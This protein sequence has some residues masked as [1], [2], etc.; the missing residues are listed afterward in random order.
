[1]TDYC[2]GVRLAAESRGKAAVGSAAFL[3]RGSLSP[4]LGFWL[5]RRAGTAML[6]GAPSRPSGMLAPP[7][8][9]SSRAATP[10]GLH[11]TPRHTPR[12]TPRSPAEVAA[13]KARLME[14]ARENIRRGI[15]QDENS[16]PEHQIRLLT[17]LDLQDALL[18]YLRNKST[19]VEAAAAQISDSRD[20]KLQRERKE[21]A[22]RVVKLAVEKELPRAAD[23]LVQALR[24]ESGDAGRWYE[25]QYGRLQR[26]A[27]QSLELYREE[28]TAVLWPTFAHVFLGLMQRKLAERARD[29]FDEHR[30]EHEDT[31]G[32]PDSDIAALSAITAP[33]QLPKPWGE[34]RADVAGT[35]LQH[36]F[37]VTMSRPAFTQLLS[38]LEQQKL[39]LIL[40]IMNAHV[41]VQIYDEPDRVGSTGSVAI[42]QHNVREKNRMGAG[43][44]P[45]LL[46]RAAATINKK[47]I[48]W[49]LLPEEKGVSEEARAAAERDRDAR[50]QAARARAEEEGKYSVKWK[51]E[52]P[53]AAKRVESTGPAPVAFLPGLVKKRPNE[54]LAEIAEL[55]SQVTLSQ[56]ALPSSCCY[57]VYNAGST[58]N[59]MAL[60]ADATVVAASF[61]DSTVRVWDMRLSS[62]PR[63]R[64]E[65]DSN[66]GAG[67]GAPVPQVFRGHSGPVYA[68]SVSPDYQNVLS[69][70]EDATVRLWNLELATNL[71]AYRGHSGAV[72]D[73][74]YAPLAPYFATASHDRTARLWSVEHAAPLRIMAGHLSDV[75]A[76]CFHNNSHYLATGSVD[77]SVRLWEL[78]AGPCVRVL[79]AHTGPVH[80]LVFS[81]CGQY[82][83]SAGA[84]GVVIIW[85]IA[86]GQIAARLQCT[87]DKQLG[88]NIWSLDYSACGKLLSAAH[89]YVSSLH[90]IPR[91]SADCVINR[92]HAYILRTMHDV[93]M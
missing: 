41:R 47:K 84:D 91:R 37:E 55:R 12:A 56:D 88:E 80:A 63:T 45:S 68:C 59:S 14:Q 81:P 36:K 65:S 93:C 30:D 35:I 4:L 16:I 25:D 92:V 89:R 34:G 24:E 33:L 8:P 71:M 7:T 70:S 50:R 10:G 26:W 74:A 61:D 9:Q 31:H 77:K 1:M 73:V 48:Y 39:L 72:W 38:F 87:D 43:N 69:C 2:D 82:L 29:F 67:W 76:V 17:K 75:D 23:C 21:L 18:G 28:L 64:D 57:T 44:G 13:V 40:H 5:C 60:T 79:S 54:Y 90:T 58:L 20:E 19:N 86:A 6:P 3:A 78:R 42:L 11:A 49:G 22:Q 85:D 83:S 32:G 15:A 27:H 52:D 51:Y 62:Q 66:P 53:S 46:S